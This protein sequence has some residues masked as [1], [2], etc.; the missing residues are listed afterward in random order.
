MWKII[1]LEN[2]NIT[3]YSNK[4]AERQRLMD[5]SEI[6]PSKH[7]PHHYENNKKICSI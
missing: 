1:S 3:M 5:K 6:Y 4:K 2:L 7:Y